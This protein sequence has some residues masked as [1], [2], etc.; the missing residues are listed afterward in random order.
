MNEDAAKIIGSLL[1]GILLSKQLVVLNQKSIFVFLMSP[2][3]ALCPSPA[4]STLFLSPTL[5]LSLSHSIGLQHSS[6]GCPSMCWPTA[7]DTVC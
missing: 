6:L 5:S 4:I 7:E 3:V 2:S 1:Y